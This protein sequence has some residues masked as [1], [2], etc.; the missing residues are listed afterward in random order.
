MLQGGGGERALQVEF[1]H[2]WNRVHS[3]GAAEAVSS[4]SRT[5]GGV[6]NEASYPD[7]F[8]LKVRRVISFTKII[9]VCVAAD[10]FLDGLD[11]HD[12]KC[13]VRATLPGPCTDE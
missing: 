10:A 4:I 9:K 2:R 5:N 1:S 7:H 11:V 3:G 12:A 6:L 13:S 8:I